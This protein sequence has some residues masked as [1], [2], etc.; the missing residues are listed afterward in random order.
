MFATKSLAELDHL[1]QQIETKIRTGG[2]SIDLDYWD[3]VLKDLAAHY[4]RMEL[5]SFFVEKLVIQI[6]IKPEATQPSVEEVNDRD[7]FDAATMEPL[8]TKELSP[9]DAKYLVLDPS[10]NVA[11]LVH[12]V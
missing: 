4:A 8:V 11:R 2:P 7:Q 9:S 12:N 1:R 6:S 3:I 10:E 5:Y